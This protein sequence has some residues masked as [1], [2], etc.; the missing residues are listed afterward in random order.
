MSPP[1]PC[2]VPSRTGISKTSAASSIA[3]GSRAPPPASTAPPP[4]RL[5]CPSASRR[6]RTRLKISSIRGW[7][8]CRIF[9]LDI[10]SGGRPPTRGMWTNWSSITAEAWQA[11]ASRFTFSA[12]S[13]GVLSMMDRSLVTWSAPRERMEVW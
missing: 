10:F 2:G 1:S 5:S 11:P 4:R 6:S 3:P 7:M 13:I 8:I 12:D 9:F